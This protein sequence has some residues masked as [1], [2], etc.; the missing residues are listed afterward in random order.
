MQELIVIGLLGVVVLMALVLLLMGS[1]KNNG[2][3]KKT[4]SYAWPYFSRY[5]TVAGVATLP[6]TVFDQMDSLFPGRHIGCIWRF[7]CWITSLLGT[8]FLSK[9]SK[10]SKTGKFLMRVF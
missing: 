6:E 4:K 10:V 7:I 3:T 1:R 9:P 5:I 8:I 2:M